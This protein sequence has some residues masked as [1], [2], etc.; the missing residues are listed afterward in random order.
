MAKKS[1]EDRFMDAADSAS[2]AG[3][4]LAKQRMS[5][6]YSL[7]G[8]DGRRFPKDIRPRPSGGTRSLDPLHVLDLAD[9][10]S[11]LG[12]LQP[13]AID[14]NNHLVAGEHR[15]EACRLLD[16][17]DHKDR[18]HHWDQILSQTDKTI[19]KSDLD[20][21]YKRLNKIDSKSY[22]NR[23]ADQQIPVLMLPLD[24]KKDTELSLA[25]ETAE[26]E[27]RQ[28]YTKQEI[29]SL[30]DRLRDAGYI[31]R[32]GRPKK[33]EKSIKSA[34]AVISGKSF[35]QIE[36]DLSK[37]KTPTHDGVFDELKSLS[38]LSK[39]F[40]RFAE[41]LPSHDFSNKF[42]SIKS[43]IDQYLASASDK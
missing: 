16:L 14:K 34:L 2:Q 8:R 9:S 20:A 27:K 18:K 36:R 13:I 37:S 30:A 11:A 29:V 35:R 39:E 17:E 28:N 24:A 15:L 3:H 42:L 1:L 33:G 31:E 12:L 5:G 7:T 38:K 41:A 23:Y 32:S 6:S 25:A 43:E 40:S 19:K 4:A 21:V 26:N 10:I 22:H